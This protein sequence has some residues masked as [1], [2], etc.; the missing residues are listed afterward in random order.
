MQMCSTLV[1]WGGGAWLARSEIYAD[2]LN[3]GRIGRRAGW[4]GQG[5][6]RWL[7]QDAAWL[8]CLVAWL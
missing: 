6:C 2:G 1:G 3:P 5:N 8:L 4:G 7:I